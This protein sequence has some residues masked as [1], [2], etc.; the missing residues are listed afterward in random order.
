[1][2]DVRA[3]VPEDDIIS[4]KPHLTPSRDDFLNA[5]NV[6]TE[7]QRRLRTG[8]WAVTAKRNRRNTSSDRSRQQLSSATSTTVSK[9][10]VYRR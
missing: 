8:I 3:R 4:E 5:R 1:M 9:Q 2:D 7:L 6:A 10:T